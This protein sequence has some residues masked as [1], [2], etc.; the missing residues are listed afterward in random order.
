MNHKSLYGFCSMVVVCLCLLGCR[1]IRETVEVPIYDTTYV[2]HTDSVRVVDSVYVEKETIVREADSA[3][4]AEYGL[5]LREGERTILVLRRELEK[6]QHSEAS[7]KADTLYKYQDVPMPYEVK[8]YVEKPLRWWQKGLMWV[9]GIVTI[10]GV[11]F[12]M[13]KIR[14]RI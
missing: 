13:Y 14:S 8:E 9:G 1:T 2:N 6:Q 11:G 5:R 3:M 7:H 10:G 4:L 12:A